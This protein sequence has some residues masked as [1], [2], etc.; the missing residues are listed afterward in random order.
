MT[1]WGENHFRRSPVQS[2]V[3]TQRKQLAQP[4]QEYS[5]AQDS[6]ELFAR[7]LQQCDRLRCMPHPLSLTHTPTRRCWPVIPAKHTLISSGGRLRPKVLRSVDVPPPQAPLPYNSPKEP[8][9]SVLY[10]CVQ[11]VCG[12]CRG[13]PSPQTEAKQAAWPYSAG[14]ASVHKGWPWPWSWLQPAGAHTD[15][16]LVR[17]SLMGC[18]RRGVG[19]HA[20]RVNMAAEYS[21]T[22]T[23]Q[24]TL[25]LPR[26]NDDSFPVRSSSLYRTRPHAPWS[27][28][29]LAAKPLTSFR[30]PEKSLYSKQRL[31]RARSN[32]PRQ[33]SSS[34]HPAK[35]PVCDGKSRKKRSSLRG[36]LQ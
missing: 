26:H 6:Q 15:Q 7:Q 1:G 17:A 11:G 2:T 23:T 34:Q 8:A 21:T 24:A 13:Q 28:F 10:C 35:S 36:G 9:I 14:R 4:R 22:G 3:T 18:L 16:R 30:H 33:T 31:S 27:W 25:T 19:R 20:S 12:F 29:S 32:P 5:G